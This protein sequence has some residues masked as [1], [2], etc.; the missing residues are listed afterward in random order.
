MQSGE[1]PSPIAPM[2]QAEMLLRRKDLRRDCARS[3]AQG[4]AFMLRNNAAGGRSSADEAAARDPAALRR[5]R[6]AKLVAKTSDEHVYTMALEQSRALQVALR[7]RLPRIQR[8]TELWCDASR[9]CPGT[10]V[11][12]ELI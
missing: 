4:G 6:S 3:L 2:S 7:E 8:A 1:T 11:E 12:G 5:Q 10:N 9:D